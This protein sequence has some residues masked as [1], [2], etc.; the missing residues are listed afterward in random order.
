[1]DQ[2][3]LQRLADARWN[4]VPHAFDQFAH[5]TDQVA[6]DVE[7]LFQ[8]AQDWIHPP[9]QRGEASVHSA[10]NAMHPARDP[11]AQLVGG[12][13]QPVQGPAG[14][15]EGRRVRDPGDQLGHAASDRSHGP[16]NRIARRRDAAADGRNRVQDAGQNLGAQRLLVLGHAAVVHVVRHLA[17]MFGPIRDR[18][19][20]IP[21]QADG[22]K[23]SDRREHPAQGFGHRFE[24][25]LDAIPR[26]A[27]LRSNPVQQAPAAFAR[28]PSATDAEQVGDEI[29]RAGDS[30]A[31]RRGQLPQL[32]AEPGDKIPNVPRDLFQEAA[33]G[34]EQIVPDAREE[35]ADRA[36]E[37]HES[38]P[39]RSGDFGHRGFQ[40]AHAFEQRFAIAL[41]EG[42]KDFGD[43]R[44]ELPELPDEIADKFT[45]LPQSAENKS[46]WR[47]DKVFEKSHDAQF[48]DFPE[49]V[50]QPARQELFDRPPKGIRQFV[51]RPRDCIGPGIIDGPGGIADRV[52]EAFTKIGLNHARRCRA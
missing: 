50:R 28:T 26:L 42:A 17:S 23:I 49:R 19:D 52:H 40:L 38:V 13:A 3:V 44:S 22:Q 25:T 30:V 16:Y 51:A 47:G 5:A 48:A 24:E 6:H 37:F 15:V 12:A 41:G 20:E 14:E 11:T 35:I 4:Q 46:E 34:F 8:S 33:D 21:D 10:E 39:H 29:P 31:H 1:M 32:A 2:E 43:P 7:D 9:R 18:A 45:R 36:E 27:G